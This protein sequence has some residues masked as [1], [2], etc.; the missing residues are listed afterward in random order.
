MPWTL[1]MTTAISIAAAP[2]ILYL[3]VKLMRSVSRLCWPNGNQ[4]S[5]LER[6]FSHKSTM[7]A[8]FAGVN[9]YPLTMI[10]I[11]DEISDGDPWTYLS[12]VYPYWTL[13]LV[14]AQ[15][16][17]IILLNDMLKLPLRRIFKRNRERWLKTE[18]YGIIGLVVFG[19]LYVGSTMYRDT[20]TVQISKMLLPVS[21]LPTTLDGFRIAHISD[22]QADPLTTDENMQRYVDTINGLKPDLVVFTGDLVTRG[23][24]YIDAG[25]RMMGRIKA[26][27][28]VIAC[29]GDH[30]VWSSSEL[31][32]IALRRN[33]V[34]VLENGHHVVIQDSARIAVSGLTSTYSRR[35]SRISTDDLAASRPPA[36][37]NMIIAH[38]PR[39]HVVES[40][41]TQ[42][43]HLFCGGHTHGGQVVVGWFGWIF[44]PV[45]TET[46]FLAGVYQMG[47]MSISINNGLG[48]TMAPVR[49]QAP[50][51]VTLITLTRSADA[52]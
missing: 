50:A 44:T 5:G 8:V 46:P 7:G 35:S 18:S 31:I 15:F 39:E 13:I 29:M 34:V 22:L 37:F 48:L 11:Q 27:H 10:L 9:I 32:A 14:V 43:Y 4:G 25:A 28:G 6:L 30:D 1:R 33:G 26:R 23:T 17:P 2:L 52:I 51:E 3:I 45:M 36:D 41:S 47:D 38:Q 19:T 16:V 49:F 24:E 20:N 12:L 40:A 42:E 21:E